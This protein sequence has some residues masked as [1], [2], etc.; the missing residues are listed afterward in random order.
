MEGVKEPGK[1]SRFVYT[2]KGLIPRLFEGL[3]SEFGNDPTVRAHPLRR[4]AREPPPRRR[5]RLS[6]RAVRGPAPS[7]PPSLAP[8]R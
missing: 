3:F 5:A 4:C 2:S 1:N 6:D 8:R 7:P